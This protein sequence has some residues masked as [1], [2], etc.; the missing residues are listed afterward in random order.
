MT[1]MHTQLTMK[2]LM[3]RGPQLAPE[4]EIVS[5]MR[6]RAHRYTYADLGRRARQLGGG[7]AE[8]GGHS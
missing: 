3:E 8:T 1:M 6:D 5:R 7:P 2:V 4:A